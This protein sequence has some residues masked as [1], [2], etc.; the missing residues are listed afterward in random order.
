MFDGARKLPLAHLSIRVP[1]NDT[2]WDGRVCKAPH[3]NNSCLILK[4]VA[5]ERDDTEETKNAGKQLTQLV[6]WQHPPCIN[7]RGF[8]MSMKDIT[9]KK[10]HPYAKQ[11][12]TEYAHFRETPFTF[13]KYSAAC[14]P[15]RWM[16][17][18]R[19]AGND[20]YEGDANRYGF[21]YQPEREP[22]LRFDNN[23]VQERENQL[24]IL[25]TFFSSVTAQESLAFFYAK[26]TPLSEERGRVIVGVGLVTRVDPHVE[27]LYDRRPATGIRCVLWERNV[28]HS[29][30]PLDGGGYAD[31][32]VFPYQQI[33]EAAEKDPNI[34]PEDYV[35][36]APDEAREQFSFASEH[37]QHDAAIGALIACAEALRKCATLV[38]GNW[39]AA[40][41]WIDAQLNRLWKLRGA[42]PGFGSALTA[43]GVE[44]GNLVAYDIGARMDA[45]E[46]K[47]RGDPWAYFDAALKNPKLF[48]ESTRELV[49]PT[50]RDL[51]KS[52][53]APRQQL[54]KLLS[55][56]ALSDEQAMRFFEPSE[57]EDAG[58]ALDD[59]EILQNAYVLFEQDR[60]VSAD[61]VTLGTIDRGLFPD[62]NLRAEH[63]VPAPS[64]VA[65]A[66]DKRRV[67]AHVVET[68]EHAALEGHTLLPRDWVI[69][70]LRD[71]AHDEERAI[72]VT[73]DLMPIVEKAFG[74]LL[75]V[76]ATADGSPAYQLDRFCETKELIAK[77]LEKRAKAKRHLRKENW[78]KLVDAQL[79]REPAKDP[80]VEEQARLEKAAALQ[81]I[82]ESRVSVLAGP[83][84]T[85]KTTLIRA[86]CELVGKENVLLLAPTGKARVRLE[87]ATKLDGGLTLAQFLLRHDRYWPDLGRYVVTGDTSQVASGY[88]TVVIDECSMLTEEQLAATLDALDGVERLILVGDPQQ[89]PPIGAGRPFLDIVHRLS[90]SG[91][92]GRFPRV[93]NGYAELTIRRRQAGEKRDDLLLADWFSGRE[94]EPAADEVWARLLRGDTL[95]HVELVRWETPD[96]LRDHL[97]EVLKRELP[98]ADLDDER[99]FE[100]SVGGSE[101]NGYVFFHPKTDKGP[102]A[103]TR[104]EAWQVLSPVRAQLHG[105]D[106]INRELQRRFR[107]Q[108]RKWSDPSR[109]GRRI[110]SPMG[111][112][113]ILYGDK[114][115]QTRNA[116]WESKWVYPKG[117]R[118]YVANGEVGVVV[119]RYNPPARGKGP[120]NSLEVEFSTQTSFKYAYAKFQFDGENGDPPLQLAYALTIHKAQGSE[121]G[122][123]F[124]VIPNPCRLLSRELLY[125]A[126]TRHQQKLVVFHQGDLQRLRDF[127]SAHHCELARRMTNL[128]RD[129]RP[130]ELKS[131]KGSRFLEEHLIHR[132][133]RGD[134]VRSK[135]EV[136]IADLLLALG[137]SYH[138][139]R[140]LTAPDGSWR[141]PDFTI[142][143]DDSG[144]K[145]FIEHLGM[146]HDPAYRD[147]WEKK[148]AWYRAQGVVPDSEGGGENGT[149]LITRDDVKGGIDSADIE[150][151]VKKI[152]A[153]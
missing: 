9:K 60:L 5:E 122:T 136:I 106:A 38:P 86:L 125:T 22:E 32:F 118:E 116:A 24:S 54:L 111:P 84:G 63:P 148:L 88:T 74:E 47:W 3:A 33:L 130:V 14:V 53:K 46:K 71:G 67:R 66:L 79:P 28:H 140:A 89:L 103:G 52:L 110:P 152:L 102:G 139:E 50:I 143:D 8:F 70:R 19:A 42:F 82:Y 31:G 57:R 117:S 62:R 25:D 23:W 35:A 68:L 123:T 93:G 129:P 101:F 98:L 51:W 113:G 17:K 104:A 135:S 1:W 45:D 83:A 134:L 58:L 99:G 150:R 10:A 131:V 4:N 65:E 146:L 149:L 6:G 72:R 49:G 109:A 145:V 7:E 121:F 40:L 43:L 147:R 127:A 90:P 69:Q 12:N 64:R 41:R 105:V 56:F 61:A 112:E 91:I 75:S 2:A 55:R 87:T 21:R 137:V 120:P 27:Y 39:D 80:E 119:G 81:E 16:L 29:I 114:V 142:I 97:L 15:F 128:F 44:R 59:E 126:L 153:M 73:T 34:N 151:R 77:K 48:S 20:E 95:D 132:T 115:I 18:E 37:V 138:Y 124:V 11:N 26:R 85:G 76:I 96:E 94:P 144:T 108:T 100:L 30:R 107:K 78:R 13:H 92:E 133:R 141:S 36:F